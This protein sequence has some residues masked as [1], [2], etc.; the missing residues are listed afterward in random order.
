MMHKSIVTQSNAKYHCLFSGAAIP[1]LTKEAT[2]HVNQ[3]PKALLHLYY[4]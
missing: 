1:L 3:Q 2:R 4:I